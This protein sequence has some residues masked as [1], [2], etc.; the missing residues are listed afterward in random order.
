LKGRGIPWDKKYQPLAL[1]QIV[2]HE[3]IR[4][5]LEVAAKK[6]SARA[7]LL[8]GPDVTDPTW[9]SE[10][11]VNATGC[12]SENALRLDGTIDR[13]MDAVRQ[14][15]APFIQAQSVFHD[16]SKVVEINAVD[17]MTL[18]AQKYL[19]TLIKSSGPNVLYVF[20][21]DS[22]SSLYANL[23][24]ALVHLTVKR[25]LANEIK[26]RL[27]EIAKQEGV[28]I[29]DIQ[30]D[31]I[32][33]ES[34]G[35][36][37]ASIISLYVETRKSATHMNAGT[38][39]SEGEKTRKEKLAG[40]TKFGKEGLEG[41]A[42]LSNWQ[43]AIDDREEKTGG[44]LTY[45]GGLGVQGKLPG[46]Q[47]RGRARIPAD[48]RSIS[49]P[50]NRAMRA[51]LRHVRGG[52]RVELKVTDQ[53]TSAMAES[54]ELRHGSKMTAI[55]FKGRFKV[56]SMKYTRERIVLELAEEH[57]GWLRHGD[58]ITVEDAGGC[59]TRLRV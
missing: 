34:R 18:D 24:G 22:I 21:A 42:S 44:P 25:L 13:G 48:F 27:R 58:Y 43:D 15:I 28:E 32:A 14:K 38:L 12:S 39:Q 59:A 40:Q 4:D 31:G 6:G 1:D 10:A 26:P 23:G 54:V 36:L 51:K 35:S 29:D 19:A 56:Q 55:V 50:P 47:L 16:D 46:A 20:T 41:D 17:S 3:A 5:I 9:L 8:Y 33:Q 2:G 30:L 49:I 57:T 53:A 11:F 7:F 52:T 37:R 45:S